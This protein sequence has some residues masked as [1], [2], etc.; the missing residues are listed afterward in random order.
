M[1]YQEVIKAIDLSALPLPRRY[2]LV[3]RDVVKV[4]VIV[5]LAWQPW[6]DS[7]PVNLVNL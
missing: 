4:L 3:T 1:S 2:T 6:G 7:V 5:I